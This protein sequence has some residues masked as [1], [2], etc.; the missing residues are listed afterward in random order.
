M[1][2]SKRI[3]AFS[4][5][6]VFLSQFQ[7]SGQRDSSINHIN[8]LFYDEFENAIK[9]AFIHNAWFTE[10]NV[11][12]ALKN[13]SVNL[14]I[15]KLNAWL[16]LYPKLKIFK[17]PKKIG[18]VMPGNIPIVGFHDFMSVL[19]S[20][21]KIVCKLS[22]EDKI[23]LRK[24]T[25]VL[26]SIEPDFSSYIEFRDGIM[27]D[28]DMLIAA[29][30]NNT[31]MHFEYYFK[32][33]PHIIRKHRNSIAIL[34]NDISREELSLLADDI[35][36]FY[37]LGCRNVSKL[38]LPEGFDIK[39]LFEAFEKYEIII[40]NYKYANNY[41]YYKSIFLVNR[42][43]HYDNGFVLLK[44][45]IRISSPVAVLYYE[46]YTNINDVLN[47][48]KNNSESI[49]CVF[50]NINNIHNAYPLGQSQI[51]ALSDYA[52]GIDTMKF[53]CDNY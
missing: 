13:L 9:E 5:L 33:Y 42:E 52:D 3:S 25:D 36:S 17:E 45:D 44:N 31:A 37:G 10:N 7:I 50:S 27:K 38:Y 11:R 14:N 47:I 32:N 35:F 53:I 26:I 43:E 39:R 16:D 29:G 8:N 20:G 12:L 15:E 21:N 49:Q 22:S 48:L 51:P 19:L 6:G 30:N 18:V 2:L 34:S 23:L 24:I 40:D 1:I 4:T 28:V 41:N 46:F